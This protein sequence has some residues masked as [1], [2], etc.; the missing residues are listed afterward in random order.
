[1]FLLRTFVAVGEEGHLTRAAER[2]HLSQPAVSAH[3]KAL[4]G[5]LDLKLFERA[6]S[7]MKLTAAGAAVFERAR[8]VLAAADELRRCAAELHGELTGTLRVGSVGDA[9]SN[10]IGELLAL[11]VS[12]HPRLRLELRQEVSGA[13]LR[14]VRER[15][16]DAAFYF[17]E[18][19]G[20]EFN[21]LP[22]KQIVYRVAGPAAWADR[23]RNADWNGVSALLWVR[24]PAI[25]THTQLVQELFARHGTRLPE[26][27]VEADS[28]SLMIELAAA[29]VG[30]CLIREDA[31]RARV[32]AGEIVLWPREK[33]RTTLWFVCL[34]DRSDE[35]LLRALLGCVKE[36][37]QQG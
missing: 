28:E 17:G 9:Q 23:I 33:L 4:E 21:A 32:Q 10:R 20:A 31:A 37:W 25:S 3:V 19:P 16:L 14:R 11:A 8:A 29:G 24:T 35:P 26:R 30:L 6:A 27:R 34:A 18:S 36:T 22:L 15:E 13:A 12:R 7:G 2:L 1:L 5:M